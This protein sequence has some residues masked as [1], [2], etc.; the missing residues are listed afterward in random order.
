VTLNLASADYE[1]GLPWLKREIGRQIVATVPI[2]RLYYYYRN[3]LPLWWRYPWT[4]IWYLLIDAL[5]KGDLISYPGNDKWVQAPT[6][7]PDR[8]KRA[9]EVKQPVEHLWHHDPPST[10]RLARCGE[11]VVNAALERAG[12]LDVRK[13]LI[14]HPT[15]GRQVEIDARAVKPGPVAGHP[16]TVA[17]EVKNRLSEILQAPTAYMKVQPLYRDLRR[18]FETAT[19][20]GMLPIVFIPQVHQSAYGWL[21]QYPA[22]ACGMLFQWLPD[23]NL[24]EDIKRHFRFGHVVCVREPNNPPPQVLRTVDAWLGRL[25]AI[26][27]KRGL[28]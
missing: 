2:L 8:A 27:A 12:F 13:A 5:E 25:P 18:E 23:Q 24:V 4:N 10:Q 6:T 16:L 14:P 19:Y 20:Y 3:N 17:A 7:R 22:L 11:D 15:D 26:M 9:Y 28:L 1:A 21:D